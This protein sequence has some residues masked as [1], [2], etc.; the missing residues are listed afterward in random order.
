V[1]FPCKNKAGRLAAVCALLLWIMAMAS[2]GSKDKA[3]EIK[4]SPEAITTTSSTSKTGVKT[5]AAKSAATTKALAAGATK[6]TPAST[7]KTMP[8][9]TDIAF[10]LTLPEGQAYTENTVPIYLKADQTIH[11]NWL[12]VKGGDHFHMTFTLPNGN[13]IAV[14]N[15]GHLNSYGR[16]ETKCEN[17]TKNGDL[18]FRPSDNDWQ[19]GYYLFHPHLQTSDPAVTVKILY[20]IE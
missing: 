11:I 20:W 18:V 7:P 14:D 4:T 16:G 10:T 6:T 2:C 13:L 3:I 5:T 8:K 15:T 19:D 12:V 9:L 17:L 1:K